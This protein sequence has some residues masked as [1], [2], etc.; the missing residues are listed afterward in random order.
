[1]RYRYSLLPMAN[2]TNPNDALNAFVTRHGTQR[3]A[4]DALGITQGYLSDLLHNK[5]DIT[6]TVL[7]KLGLRKAVVKK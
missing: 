4:A 2:E 6:D 1:M 3:K 5:R 7:A